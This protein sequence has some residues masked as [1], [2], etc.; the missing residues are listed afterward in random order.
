MVTDKSLQRKFENLPSYLNSLNLAYIEELENQYKKDP[1]VLEPTWRSFFDGLCL[2][3][4][5]SQEILGGISLNE[6]EFEHK[7]MKL[8][9]GYRELGYLIADV[10]PLERGVQ[11]HP[12]LEL[13][14]FGL[15]EEDLDKKCRVAQT[16]GLE[17]VPLRAVIQWLTTYYGSPVAVEYAHIEEPESRIWIQDQVESGILQKPL[18]AS[19]K[20]RTFQK[21]SEAEALET[22]FHKRFV[23]QKRFSVEGNDVIV[24]MLDYLVEGASEMGTDEML[25]AMAHRGRLNVLANIFQKDLKRM[26]AEFTGNLEAD[27]GEGDVKYHMGFSQ[28]IQTS[29]GRI[30]YLSL[31]RNPSH[32]EAVNPVLMGIARS[33]QKL[34]GDKQRIRTLPVLIHGDASFSG[35]GVIYEIL[36][37]SELKGYSVGGTLHI[38][39]NNRIGYTT[40]SRESRSTPQATDVA[41]MLEIPIFRVNADEPE[42]ALRCILLALEFRNV[43]KRD[44]VIDLI[45]YRRYGHN[46]A[47]EPTYTQPRMYQ[48]IKSHPRVRTLYAQRLIQ[49]GVVDEK[50]IEET[51]QELAGR[52]DQAL[53]E[54]RKAPVSGEMHPFGGRWSGF[55]EVSEEEILKPVST[56]VSV[57]K[58]KALSQQLL[59]IPEGFHLHPKLAKALEEKRERIDGKREVD[60]SLGET[61]AYATLLCDGHSVRLAGQ[62]SV[63]GTFSHRHATFYDYETGAG[64]TPLNH[65]Q[66]AKADFE[67]V[68][69]SL[70]EFAALGFELGQSF[71]DPNKLTIWEAQFG[72]FANGAQIIIDQF[73]VASAVKWSQYSG[74]VLYL[75]HGYEGQGAEHSS[76]RLERFLQACAQNNIQVC[77]FTTPAQLF[78]AL[79]RQMLREIRLPLIVM[80]P[81]SLLRHPRVTSPWSE[82]E[83]GSFQEA[84]DDP[85][86]SLKKTAKRVVLCSGKIYYELLE[87]REKVGKEIALIRLEQFYPFPHKRLL[88]I[89]GSYK[90]AKEF[91]WCQEEPRNMGGWFFVRDFLRGQLGSHEL[92][93]VSRPYQA[94]PADGYAHLHQAV[95]Q[96]IVRN[97]IGEKR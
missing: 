93:G 67:V 43:F 76:A 72:D 57:E 47:D 14:C 62:D 52:L 90:K 13:S 51:D 3:G 4:M 23:G 69:S 12:L 15:K 2:N 82:F 42:P 53:E 78:H 91:I 80:T 58:L 10:D 86:L 16:L 68:N 89:L 44:V 59:T 97:A 84:L 22:F 63:R 73:L 36:N 46:E 30:V 7:V 9:E 5:K 28:N 54:S 35:Q 88:E 26:F 87:A 24:P 94:S 64:Y 45:G 95:Q 60:W 6:L 1:K 32:L 48:R 33:K 49:E 70:S 37:M 83:E 61:L 27:P 65:L 25:I 18:P 20:L 17:P 55:R 40:M 11:R 56:G 34:K 79:R 85:N 41:K 50:K 75:P 19:M 77:N 8:I 38:I 81:K 92:K 71:A 96:E 21:L 39:L 31:V 66:E 74:L 29:S